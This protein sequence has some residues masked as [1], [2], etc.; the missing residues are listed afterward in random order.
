MLFYAKWD[1]FQS[2]A[3]NKILDIFCKWNQGLGLNLIE[4]CFAMSCFSLNM[5]GHIM[6]RLKTRGLGFFG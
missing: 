2:L 5:L 4:F 1:S 6:L 3:N